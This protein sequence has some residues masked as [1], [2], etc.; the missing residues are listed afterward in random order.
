MVT[1]SNILAWEIPWTEKP[2]GLWSIGSQRVG[3]D[4]SNLAQ[5]G[6]WYFSLLCRHH[7]VSFPY[8]LKINTRYQNKALLSSIN[9]Y[10]SFDGINLQKTEENVVF[11]QQ[12]I[13]QLLE[14]TAHI[15]EK[16]TQVML[17]YPPL[18]QR[19]LLFPQCPCLRPVGDNIWGKE[20]QKRNDNSVITRDK[21]QTGLLS[22]GP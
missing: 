11:S 2:G 19:S 18:L 8:F 12:W 1:Y 20:V 10:T 17:R 3:H 4:W 9:W 6:K 7:L 13:A 21:N 16:W 15:S 22:P 14:M 5:K